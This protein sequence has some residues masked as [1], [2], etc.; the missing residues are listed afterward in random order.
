MSESIT[1]KARCVKCCFKKDDYRIFSWSPIDHNESVKL[2]PYFTFSTK[3]ND[4]YIDENKDYEI[5]IEEIAYD[6]R[7]GGTYKILSVPSMSNFDVSTLTLD[8]KKEILMDCTTSERIANN[9]LE[10]YPD[11]IELILTK[12]K[13]A[14][15]VS[16]IKGVG[17]VYLGAYARNL[18]EKYKY[19]GIIQHFKDY[20]FDVSDCKKLIEEYL[21]EEHI[22]KEIQSNPYKVLISTLGRSFEFA[23]RMI[24]EL[25]E[26][27]KVSEMRCAYLILS[28]LER[29]EQEGSTRL[30][31]NDLYY[32]IMEEYNVPELEPLIVPTAMNND[33]FYYDEESKDL[34]IMSTYQGE[35][36]VADFVK[37]KIANSTQLDI[38]WTQYTTIDDFTM[39]EKQGKALEMFCKYN[40][41]ILAGYSGSGKAQP[42]DT[43]IPT[44]N[45]YKKLGDIKVGDYVYDR[46][47]KPTKVLGVYPQGALDCYTVTLSDGR[48][49]QCNDEHLWSYYTNRGNLCTKT[50]REMIDGGIKNKSINKYKI[51]TNKAIE[52]N[53]K[54]LPLDPYVLGSFIG[55]GCCKER[56]LTISS[57]D[58][59]QVKMIADILNVEY[60]KN[61]EKNYSWGFLRNDKYVSPFNGREVKYLHTKDILPKEIC[62]EAYQKRIPTEYK[63]GSIE[64]RYS[65]LQG[66]F[67]TD[68][69]INNKAPRFNMSYCTTS[70]LLADDIMEV[71]RSLGYICSMSKDKRSLERKNI[72]NGHICYEINLLCDNS[73]KEKFFRLTRKK[74]IAIKAKEYK[75]HRNYNQ[76]SI[77]NIKKEEYQKEMVCI[78]VDNDEHLYLTND[79]IVTH[80][81]TSLKGLIKLMESNG[82]T[83]TLLAPTGKASR[84]I[85]ESVNRQASTI[86]RKA[87]RDGEISTDVLIV[88]EMSMTDLPTFLMMLNVIENPNIRVVLVGDPAQLMPVGI[89]CVFNDLINSGKVPMITLDEIFRYDTD[90]GIFVATNVRQGKKF[91][92][93]DIVKVHNNEYSVYNNYKFVQ[94]DNIFDTIVE[95]Y[96]KLLSKGVKPHDIL[97]LS[98]FNVG[99][100]GSYRINNAIQAEVNPPKPNEAHLDRKVDKDKTII[101]FRVGDKLLNKKNDYQALPYDS[102]KEIEQSDNMLSLDDVA[103]TSV[104]NGQDGVIR[105]LDDKK[106]IAQF[107]E[108]LIVFDKAKLQNLLLAY[109]ISV[110]AS[111]GSEAKYVLN[112]VS[113]SHKRML[114]RNLLYVADTRSKIMQID[115]GDM[116]TYNDALLIDGNAE[117]DTW[118]K[119]LMMKGEDEIEN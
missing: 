79:Y 82:M 102:W 36:K 90:G 2:S 49:T 77:T 86:H 3:G 80:N 91:F 5:E 71:L 10:A 30:N 118:L 53:Y 7:Y 63:Y 23:D 69:Y 24:M 32:Y 85:T 46:F 43:I 54:E 59:E 83:Y 44:P 19:L 17:E 13:E 8:Q 94:T 34:S 66:L 52:Y 104:F 11:F 70:K 103:L 28:V 31:G 74:E 35:C 101:S 37:D 27:L 41:M 88:D 21:D 48:K 16:R 76:I 9:I 100:E 109:C 33:L 25:R 112:V 111:Q 64:Q 1:L 61:H 51:P 60:K 106:L 67:D 99:D 92:D 42:I 115:I 116:A 20:K 58:E 14:I 95:Q 68:G 93:N 4:S 107:D 73:E 89:G 57:N 39:S 105:E 108:E 38:D 84:R 47:G 113:P 26:D 62:C 72:K 12:G 96:N 6:K 75:K 18:L 97:C 56:A 119:E 114:N 110:H 50:L 98:P 45:G 78:Y 117:R 65:L 55:N 29:N 87:L 81:T 15:D 40:F 22:T